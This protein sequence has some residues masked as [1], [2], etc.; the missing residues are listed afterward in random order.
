MLDMF[1]FFKS[2]KPKP[3][4]PNSYCAIKFVSGQVQPHLRM[5]L[6]NDGLGY[7]SVESDL[8]AILLWAI[9]KSK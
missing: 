9:N 7:S 6:D 3:I 1:N 4:N 8:N 5:V 2:N